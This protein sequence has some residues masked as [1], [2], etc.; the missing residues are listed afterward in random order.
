MCKRL[1]ELS[2]IGSNTKKYCSLKNAFCGY[3]S[4]EFAAETGK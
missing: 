4:G 1:V 3:L 2:P